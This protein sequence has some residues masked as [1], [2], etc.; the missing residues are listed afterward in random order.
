[1]CIID[2]CIIDMCIIDTCIIDTVHHRYVHHRYV[3]H[4]YMYHRCVIHRC[5]GGE[6]GVGHTFAWV[7]RPEGPKSRGLQ[8]FQL[9][10]GDQRAPKTSSHLLYGGWASLSGFH[11]Q[12]GLG[13]YFEMGARQAAA[14]S[15]VFALHLIRI[16][17][18]G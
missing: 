17:G 11:F 4:R 7:T 13:E 8:G 16:F 1:M 2:T 15:A 12:R 9:E 18:S 5:R 14:S 6:E 3:H 10:V